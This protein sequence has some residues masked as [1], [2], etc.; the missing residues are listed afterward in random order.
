MTGDK[1]VEI[2]GSIKDSNHNACLPRRLGET[3]VAAEPDPL[4]ELMKTLFYVYKSPVEVPWEATQ[5][6]L[7]DV[8]AK[9]FITHVDLAEIISADKCLNISILQLWT[10]FM[11]NCG[12]SK[13]D[14]S[15]YGLLEPQSIHNAK[16]RREQCQEYIQTWVKESQRQLYLGVYL[17]QA[18]WQLFVL[19][20]RENTIVWFCSLRKKPDINI[21]ATINRFYSNI[22]MMSHVQ[23]GAYECGYYVM[24]WMWCIV[25]G[26]LKDDWN[27]VYVMHGLTIVGLVNIC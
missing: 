7:P 18:H 19:C 11:N 16:D 6:G 13:V 10:I 25:T 12:R 15:L 3:E 17:H 14:Q 1:L 23:T 20:P 9:F 24:H 5:F 22:Q 2:I 26:G 4:G 8:G 21:K 27:K